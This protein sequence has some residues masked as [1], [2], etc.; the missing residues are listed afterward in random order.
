MTLMA[1]KMQIAAQMV[2]R[3]L[4]TLR[5]ARNLAVRM[6]IIQIVHKMGPTAHNTAHNMAKMVQIAP[7][8]TKIQLPY[9][10]VFLK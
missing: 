1:V 7:S 8:A 5:T 10:V 4:Q 3:T 2:L 6:E 9:Q